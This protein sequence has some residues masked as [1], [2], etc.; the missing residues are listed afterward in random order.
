MS[1]IALPPSAIPADIPKDVR[2][3]IVSTCSEIPGGDGWLHEI[4]HDGHR[5]VAI[6]SRRRSVAD[7]APHAQEQQTVNRGGGLCSAGERTCCQADPGPAREEKAPR[8]LRR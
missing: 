6:I 4:K 2:L 5:L 8:Y 3:Q 1:S 7:V